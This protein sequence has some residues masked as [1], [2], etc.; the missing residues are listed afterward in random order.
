MEVL[1]EMYADTLST[2]TDSNDGEG[3]ATWARVN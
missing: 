1:M 3:N 2:L